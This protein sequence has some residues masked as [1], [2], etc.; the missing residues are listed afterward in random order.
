VTIFDDTQIREWFEDEK[1]AYSD[2]ITGYEGEYAYGYHAL[3][4]VHGFSHIPKKSYNHVL[5]VGSA[6][7]RMNCFP[8]S[9][10]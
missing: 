6:L 7:R 1:E 2:L 4:S 3:N 10:E 8:Y 5:G 9:I